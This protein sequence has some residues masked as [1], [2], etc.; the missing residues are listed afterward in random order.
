MAENAHGKPPGILSLVL[1]PAVITLLVTILRLVGELEGW[2]P[3]FFATG[4]MKDGWQPGWVGISWLMPIFGLWFG[5]RLQ[6][7]SGE[8]ERLGRGVALVLVALGVLV[9]GFV[10]LQK[11]G[12]IVMPSA[13]APG[14]PSGTG[15]ALCL[16]VVA[17]LLAMAAWWRLG[18]VLLL[19]AVL[20]RIPVLVVTYLAV[21][22]G[23]QTHHVLLPPGFP[24]VEGT[25]RF[26]SLAIS[27]V[28]FWIV[29]TLMTGGLFGLLGARLARGR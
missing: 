8:P 25:E 3:S 18:R 12:V 17:A 21:H 28:T 14:E 2:A 4:D 22:N 7:L 1:V 29:A 6:R 19:Y 23:W 16:L 5:F 10:G 9:G 26:F 20:A 11:L 13:E 24:D 27:Q 15:Y